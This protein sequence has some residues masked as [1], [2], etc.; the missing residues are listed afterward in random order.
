MILAGL[1]LHALQGLRLLDVTKA[2][3]RIGVAHRPF[4]HT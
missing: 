2:M 4:D 1:P 3:R